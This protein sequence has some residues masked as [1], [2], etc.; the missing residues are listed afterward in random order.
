MSFVQEILVWAA[1]G[2]LDYVTKHADSL[3]TKLD[4]FVKEG[5]TSLQDVANKMSPIVGA[6]V[7]E[8]VAVLGPDVPK[9]EGDAVAWVE[10]ALKAFI[11]KESGS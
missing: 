2:V 9:Y 8:V 4:G 10:A 7:A 11:A 1:N 5:E 6:V 3:K